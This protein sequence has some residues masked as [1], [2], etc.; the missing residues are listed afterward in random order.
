[1]SSQNMPWSRTF[2]WIVLS[3]WKFLHALSFLG[4]FWHPRIYSRALSSHATS[5][6][7]SPSALCTHLHS[8]Q[9][10]RSVVS[11]SLRPHESQHARPPCPSPTPG[12]HSDSS[13]SSQWCHPAIPSSVIPFS[14]CPQSLPASSIRA[15]KSYC[16]GFLIRWVLL[17]CKFEGGGLQ[18]TFRLKNWWKLEPL[19]DKESNFH[20]WS[21][22]GSA[23]QK[24]LVNIFIFRYKL[25]NQFVDSPK[26]T[27]WYS[28]QDYLIYRSNWKELASWYLSTDMEY[29]PIY[30]IVLFH[31]SEFCSFP[32]T[33]LIHILLDLNLIVSFLGY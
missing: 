15:L 16:L 18:I 32:H 30:I 11:D 33:D 6:L 19:E 26:I 27:C 24:D 13:P 28:D 23:S 5:E 12:V 9:F 10:S 20:L 4:Y 17:L 14:S 1:M 22:P 3:A 29:F 25:Q 31:S 21:V 2:T 7:Q 8:V